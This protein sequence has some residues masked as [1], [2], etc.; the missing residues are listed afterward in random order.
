M[1]SDLPCEENGVYVLASALTPFAIPS[2]LQDSL[3]ARL[4]RLAHVKEIAQIG[5][6]IGREFSY[7]LLEAVSPIQEQAL[8]DA[9]GQLVAANLLHARGAPPDAKYTFKHALVQDT[10]YASLLRGRRQRIHADIAKALVESFLDQV[11]SARAVIAH[12]YTEAGLY[13]PAA[14]HW[15]AA[16]ELAL[17]RSAALEADRHVD[18]GLAVILRM[19]EGHDRRSLELAFLVAKANALLPLKGYS[20]PETVA[21][22]TAAK[23]LLDVGIGDDLQHFSVLYGLCAA[24]YVASELDSARALAR[25]FVGLAERQDDPIYRLVGLRLLGTVQ[26]FMGR[27][28]EDLEILQKAESY[29][30]P[31]R[32]RR[33]S[34]RFGY[35][36]SLSVLCYKTM[37]LFML[38]LPDEAMRA[39][40][41]ACA[42]AADHYHAPTVALCRFFTAIWPELLFGDFEAC[43]RHSAELVAYCIGK[44]VEQFRLYAVLTNTCAR[45]RRDPTAQNIVAIRAAHDAHHRS[46]ARILDSMIYPTW[47]RPY[48][49]RAM[50]WGLKQRCKRPSNLSSFLASGFCLPTCIVSLVKLALSRQVSDRA[51]AEACFL[52]AIEVARDQGARLLELRAATDLAH[53]WRNTGSSN[54]PR[55]L[56]EPIL[57]P[58]EGGENMRDVRDARA[59]LAEN[60]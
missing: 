12:H 4:D 16:S 30:D 54:D 3:M 49:R 59:L 21:A 7:R 6:A 43:E 17:S 44:K 20:T 25:Q 26:F 41:Q 48:W 47:L 9:L 56:L 32:Q 1:S 2:T 18:A 40:Y 5:A 28:R 38:G 51:R 60:V 19:Q 27:N 35:D 50:S 31:P 55:P 46:G 33:L 53:L 8:Q 58:I 34:Y 29:R 11:D 52:K 42:E 13:E 22:L 36:P 45:A 24:K 37:T 57:A 15:L 23:Q 10:A 14:R 39:G